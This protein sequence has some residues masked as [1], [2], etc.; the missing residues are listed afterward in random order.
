MAAS[1]DVNTPLSPIEHNRELRRAIIAATVGTTIEWYDFLLY[2]TMA[3]LVFGKLFFPYET[4]L[5][6]TLNAFDLYEA[7]PSEGMR[8]ALRVP[9]LPYGGGA[10][11]SVKLDRGICL[12]IIRGI[13]PNANLTGRG[14]NCR[15][16]RNCA[17]CDGRHDVNADDQR[18][19]DGS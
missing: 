17:R 4:T 6:A 10:D 7:V 9:N 12:A 11:A 3:G 16:G 2:S 8:P 19:F 5:T 13:A 1:A 18:S 14:E 15:C